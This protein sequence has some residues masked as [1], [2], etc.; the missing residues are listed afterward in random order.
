VQQRGQISTEPAQLAVEG[1]ALNG[2]QAAAPN[3]GGRQA[4]RVQIG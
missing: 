3:V 4:G 1:D 2:Q